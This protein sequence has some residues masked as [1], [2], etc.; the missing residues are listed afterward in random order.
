MQKEVLFQPTNGPA[1]PGKQSYWHTAKASFRMAESWQQ[2]IDTTFLCWIKPW[3]NQACVELWQQAAQIYEAG[4]ADK[5]PFALENAVDLL[6]PALLDALDDCLTPV[7]VFEM[8]LAKI[9][10]LL[11]GKT[12]Q[13]KHQQFIQLLQTPE[14]SRKLQSDYP[15]LISQIQLLLAQ[16][17]KTQAEML[18]RLRD[19]WAH[20]QRVFAANP[21]GLMRV[22]ANLGDT[23]CEGR[24][25]TI[26]TFS[27]G[28]KLVYKPKSQDAA[29]HFQQFL[30]WFN[31][32]Q[33]GR[34][35]Y[36]TKLVPRNGY[37]WVE[38]LQYQPCTTEDQVSRFY[39]RQGAYLA[40]LYILYA[41]DIHHENVMAIGEHPVII[42]LESLFH[43]FVFGT[44]KKYPIDNLIKKKLM[45]SVKYSQML[46]QRHK[47]SGADAGGLGTP[48][49][50]AVADVLHLQQDSDGELSY[51][52]AEYTGVS[53][54]HRPRLNGQDVDTTL[55][56]KDI[57][58][59]FQSAYKTILNNRQ[60]LLDP[61][62]PLAQFNHDK[63]RVVIRDSKAYSLILRQ[64]KNPRQVGDHS[65]YQQ[66]LQLLEIETKK[67][68]ELNRLLAHE[69]SDL[70]TLDIPIFTTTPTARHLWSSQGQII[71]NY[72]N[73]TGLSLA[74]NVIKRLGPQDFQQQQWFIQAS[75]A[76]LL[77][78]L[79]HPHMPRY[80][81]PQTASSQADLLQKTIQEICQRL[82]DN[83]LEA[84]AEI[85]WVGLNFHENKYWDINAT[86]VPL[87]DGLTGIVLF[88]AYLAS[89]THDPKHVD[90]AQKGASTIIRWIKDP[91]APVE[92]LGGFDGLG[93]ILHLFAHLIALWPDPS[94]LEHATLLVKVI[95][96]RL[97]DEQDLGMQ[98][99]LAGCLLAL[100]NVYQVTKIEDAWETA[101]SC[102]HRLINQLH[103]NAHQ[104]SDAPGM[105]TS[106]TAIMAALAKLSSCQPNPQDNPFQ[107]VVQT[108]LNN[109]SIDPK[110][111]KQTYL[112]SELSW[113][114]GL[115]GEA[116]A[117]IGIRRYFESQALETSVKTITEICLQSGFG[118]N[119]SLN[120]G[121]LGV[122]DLLMLVT[123]ET[124]QSVPLSIQD[125][126]N[127]IVTS[128]QQ[129][130][131]LCGTPF[132]LPTFGLMTGLAGIGYQLL[133]VSYPEQV[134]S[135]LLLD[136][137]IR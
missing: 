132:G 6:L 85:A 47:I 54:H 117:N 8:R 3:I 40:V 33:E 43:P 87:F 72:L 28:F 10:G 77:D 18:Q 98:S 41:S 131:P 126:T 19:D 68:P 7:M 78:G 115:L 1:I 4:S 103:Q 26:L 69:Y 88:Y 116:I 59:G 130:G 56:L 66:N 105:Q 90:I 123:T 127:R 51:I 61:N 49:H 95:Q 109:L 97:A 46:P 60:E 50:Q 25:V 83:L 86:S 35:F 2:R 124:S 11:P 120:H 37:G 128:I 48:D 107:Q 106:P 63:V 22:E 74:Q 31:S 20:I 65:A 80:E 89:I 82:E 52:R 133:R 42:D 29:Y 114:N 111:Q 129:N 34:P 79:D 125:Q 108:Y 91:Q 53:G 30:T 55:Y 110:A 12:G 16:W 32:K 17:Q 36:I 45:D 134:P 101:V 76:S 70:R 38:Y 5:R 75:F 135:I 21:G 137:P 92:S 57:L 44:T 121:D 119:H 113:S 71:P 100:L 13:E 58:Q 39:Q 104:P 14:F 136:P 24:S 122:I 93:G 27:S 15:I 81:L 102:G 73:E 84:D 94:Y 64:A 23:H 118:Y 96:E 9:L 67:K 62:G 112:P 99:G